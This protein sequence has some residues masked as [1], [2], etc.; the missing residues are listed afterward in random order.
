MKKTLMI[1]VVLLSLIWTVSA[2]AELKEGLWEITTQVELKGMPGVPGAMPPTAFRQCITKNDAVPKNT[3]K[4]YECKTTLQNSV[5]NTIN[6][7]VECKGQDTVMQTSGT[8]TYTGNTMAGQSNTT[9]KTKGQPAMQMLSKIKGKYIGP[10]P[11]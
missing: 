11:K 2:C 9:F 8:T 4:N 3:D 5:G 10:C 6:Y 7:K 1:F